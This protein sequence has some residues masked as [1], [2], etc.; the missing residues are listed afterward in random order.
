MAKHSPSNYLDIGNLGEDLTV[1]WLVSQG[2]II[3]HR[4]WH[5]RW[6]EIDIIAEYTNPDNGTYPP[7]LPILAFVEVK[8]RSQGSW[9]RGG[10]DAIANTKQMK[11][12]RTAQA[13][14]SKY[15][16]KAEYTCR[17]DVALVNYVLLTDT[18]RNDNSYQKLI[19]Q[20]INNYYLYLQEYIPHAF[21]SP[22]E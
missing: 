15:P 13:F 16:E 14:I 20:S 11:I 4:Q 9:D 5:S 12:Y 19:S 6:G 3:L 21:D 7:Q 10:R 17:F 22:K 8:T 2:W 1:Q 18:S